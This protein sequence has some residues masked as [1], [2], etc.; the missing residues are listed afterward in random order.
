MNCLC[1]QKI[2]HFS[3]DVAE[4]ML[5]WVMLMWLMLMLMWVMLMWV[6]LLSMRT[7]ESSELRITWYCVRS[8]SRLPKKVSFQSS[9]Q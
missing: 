5:M 8:S 4:L 6:M 3:V 9:S 1:V 2:A 7:A